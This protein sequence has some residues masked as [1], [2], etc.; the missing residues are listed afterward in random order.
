[1]SL[2][3]LGL[4]ATLFVLPAAGALAQAVPAET[5]AH[6]STSADG[7]SA[8]LLAL[9]GSAVQPG[10]WS[11]SS[12]MTRDGQTV[13]L[14]ERTLAVSA[15]TER[16]RPAWLIVDQIEAAGQRM[17][18]SLFVSRDSLQPLR[19]VAAMGP[20]TIRNAFT[21]DSI[22]GSQG[23]PDAGMPIALARP[24]ALMVNSG[25]LETAFTLVPLHVGWRATVHQLLA[26]PA[27][28][29]LVPVDLEV[30]GEDTVTVSTGPVDAWRLSATA[31]GAEQTIWLAKSDRRLVRMRSTLAQMQGVTYETVLTGGK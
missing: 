1:M 29:T 26:G 23:L 15:A 8:A 6:D 22:T 7:A 5:A 24:S 19:R 17:A 28:T 3:A 27:G 10:T 25:M 18:D 20:M 31:G 30:I 14:G 4:A 11:Y 2:R 9:D 13:A 21:A 12:T 16:E